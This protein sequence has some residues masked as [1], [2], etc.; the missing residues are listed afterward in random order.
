MEIRKYSAALS[1]EQTLV[2]MAAGAEIVHAR[3][4]GNWLEVWAE[5]DEDSAECLR[6]FQLAFPGD[7]LLDN[8][9]YVSTHFN[10]PPAFRECVLIYDAGELPGELHSVPEV[11]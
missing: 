11:R 9:E 8:V 1:G 6:M 2:Q 3:L 5:V 4:N 7:T 10:Q